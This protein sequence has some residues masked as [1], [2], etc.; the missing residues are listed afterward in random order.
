MQGCLKLIGVAVVALMLASLSFVS[1]FGFSA[2][3]SGASSPIAAMQT[4]LPNVPNVL[5]SNNTPPEFAVFWEAWNIIQKD[6]YG[7]L[8]TNKQLAYGAIHA[9]LKTLND[10]HTVFIEPRDTAQQNEQLRGDFQGIGANVNL[11][12]GQVVIVSP[13]P[14]SPAEKAGILAGDIIVNVDGKDV[15]GMTLDDVVALIRG[16]K[17]TSVKITIQR[18]DKPDPLVL[19]IIRNT[20]QLPSVIAKMQE[21]NVG[22][23][24]LTIFGEKS[25][26]EVVNA[27]NDLKKQGAKGLIFDLRGNPGGYLQAAIDVASQFIPDGVVA[28]ERGKD[29]NEQVFKASGNGAWTDL[30]MVVLIDKG[31]ASAS[32]IVS[33]AIQDRKR[34]PLL[35][36]TSFGKGSVQS[37]HQLSDQS[38]VHVTIAEWLTPNKTQITGKGLT[39]DMPVTISTDDQKNGVDSQLQAAIKYLKE[40]M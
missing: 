24:R 3:N 25:K 38:S 32:E 17:G 33:G 8:P 9:V 31:S 35:G 23:V 4:A 18:K 34:A 14:G 36:E 7:T 37:V 39:P 5:Q 1:G 2:N 26:D 15:N 22:Y 28:Y 13:I 27:I 21:N 10:Q 19:D 40:K 30:P 20:I 16:P 11:I 12:G 29:G 6:F